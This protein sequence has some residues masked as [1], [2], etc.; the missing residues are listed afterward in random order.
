MNENN[1]TSDF[2]TDNGNKERRIKQIQNLYAYFKNLKA[3]QNFSEQEKGELIS[4]ESLKRNFNGDGGGNSEYL[5]NKWQIDPRKVT[6]EES[7][8]KKIQ[9]IPNTTVSLESISPKTT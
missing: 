7:L 4:I 2:F 1:V 9:T 6:F 3:G 8:I 5:E